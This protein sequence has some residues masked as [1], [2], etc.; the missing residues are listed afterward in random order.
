MPPNT[1]NVKEPY[2]L[3]SIDLEDIR[4]LIAE[5]ERYPG[6]VEAMT[7]RYLE[8]LDQNGM[9][10]TFFV[11][12][13]VAKHHPGLIRRIAAAGHEIGTH[14][15][16]HVPLDKQ[17]RRTFKDDLCESIGHI[18]SAGASEV[19]GFRAPVFSL[20]RETQWAYEVLRELGFI[21]SSSV[22]PAKNPLY[23]WPEF[24]GAIQ[25]ING[26]WELPMSLI[27]FKPLGIPFAGGVYFRILPDFVILRIFRH[28]QSKNRPVLGYFHPY[29]I[30]HEQGRFMH[31]GINNSRLYNRLMYL[32]RKSLLPR[33]QKM[34]ERS[35]STIIPY[36]EYVR[37]VLS[38]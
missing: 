22:L 11:V 25:K 5:G 36:R 18:L 23:G 37:T 29:D 16:R 13:Q 32:R 3:F 4:Y 24:G 12:G 14:T 8:F 2:Y 21:Y 26:I 28:Y 6:R 19:V 38:N 34:L 15:N 27:P 17:D 35:Q 9:K 1:P 20:T 31:P 10:A 33:M 7:D 30:D